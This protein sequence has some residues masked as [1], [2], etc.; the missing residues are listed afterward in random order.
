MY[1]GF[2]MAQWVKNQPA[3]QETGDL[4]FTLDWKD[5]LE[6]SGC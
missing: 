6:E 1:I 5:L 4:G 2:P 3:M